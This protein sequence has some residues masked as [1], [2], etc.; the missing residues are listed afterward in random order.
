M[1]R[2]PIKEKI[3]IQV[4]NKFNKHCAYCG[5]KLEYKDMQVDHLH[6]FARK[7]QERDLDPNRFDNLM[8]SC[9]SCNYYKGTYSLERY[10]KSI[11]GVQATLLR[12]ASKFLVKL[13]VRYGIIEFKEFDGIFYF[14][15]IQH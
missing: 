5:I 14:E 12:G 11:H 7:H 8:P 10:R 6:P 4:W 9:R 1:K 3:R 2:K 13:A 15:K